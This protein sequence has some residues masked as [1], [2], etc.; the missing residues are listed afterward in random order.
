[1]ILMLYFLY[2]IVFN[3][4][5]THFV[6]QFKMTKNRISAFIFRKTGIFFKKSPFGDLFFLFFKLVKHFLN[7]L[8]TALNKLY[9]CCCFLDQRV[10]QQLCRPWEKVYWEEC[11]FPFIHLSYPLIEIKRS[12]LVWCNSKPTFSFSWILRTSTAKNLLLMQKIFFNDLFLK[13]CWI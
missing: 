5:Y 3:L 8:W 6:S 9:Y 7:S 10:S 4:R 13:E 12:N 11:L 2:Y 1:M